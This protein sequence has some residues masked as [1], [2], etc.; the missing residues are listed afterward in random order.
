MKCPVCKTHEHS[1]IHLQSEQ[2]SEDISK[3]PTCGTM[4]S[5][6]HGV[7][8]VVKDAQEKSFLQ[9]QSEPVEGDDYNLPNT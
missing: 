9:A 3:C 5:E 1:E 7:I 8:E 6:N 4:W 2:F